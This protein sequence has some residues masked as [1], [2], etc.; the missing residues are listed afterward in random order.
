MT[1]VLVI[2]DAATA[3][4]YHRAVLERAGLTVD[5]ATNGYEAL[6][7]ALQGNY[8]LFL[9]DVIMPKMDGYAFVRALHAEP[10]TRDARVVLVSSLSSARDTALGLGAGASLYL[11]KPVPPDAL[12]S[13][14]RLLLGRAA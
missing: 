3:R 6:E 2:D 14:V 5:E 7:R 13:H 8:R 12:V 4:S 1:D 11:V 10:A 9:C